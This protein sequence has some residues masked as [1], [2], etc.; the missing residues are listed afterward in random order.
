MVDS[1]TGSHVNFRDDTDENTMGRKKLGRK[2]RNHAKKKKNNNK[3][4][5]DISS[6]Q[7]TNANTNVN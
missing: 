2:K 5:L 6:K 7:G 1:W 3:T 4:V